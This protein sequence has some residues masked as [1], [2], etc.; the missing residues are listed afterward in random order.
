MAD[1]AVEIVL[2]SSENACVSKG[3]LLTIDSP[4]RAFHDEKRRQHLVF[5]NS[6]AKTYQIVSSRNNWLTEKPRFTAFCNALDKP[7]N[8]PVPAAF[9]QRVFVQSLYYREGMLMAF[10]HNEYWGR[11][12]RFGPRDKLKDPEMARN[13]RFEVGANFGRECRYVG[14]SSRLNKIAP[15]G[16]VE[17]VPGQD[18]ASQMAMYPHVVY[19]AHKDSSSMGWIGY[20]TPTNIVRG[21]DP[22]HGRPDGNFY[23]L[24]RANAG[25]PDLKA[26]R[27]PA[28]APDFQGQTRGLCLLQ[29]KDPMDPRSWGIWNGHVTN[30]DFS[31][32]SQ[33]PYINKENSPC[34]TI[35]MPGDV[36][37]IVYHRPSRHYVAIVQTSKQWGFITSQ[38]LIVWSPMTKII[39]L[40]DVG[41]PL[42]GGV[43][44]PSVIDHFGGN[45]REKNFDTVYSDKRSTYLYFRMNHPVYGHTMI[46]R[47][48]ISIRSSNEKW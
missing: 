25:V 36:R 20:G 41:A 7:A 13:C 9:D 27:Q 32:Q 34:A 35:T 12:S 17:E 48:K 28:T 26:K 21:F 45:T 2:D 43:S 3:A 24:A 6:G 11:V 14:I 23:F 31:Q 22:L 8:N 5:S 47:K 19:P 46:G 1:E 30:P 4:V 15:D 42:K 18:F 44:Y 29:S 40:D 37:S 16:A 38:N 39:E 33:N 10:G